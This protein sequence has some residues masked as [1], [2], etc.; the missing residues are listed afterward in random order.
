MNIVENEKNVKKLCSFYVSDFHLVTMLL[1]YVSKK[2]KEDAKIETIL[3]KSI[4]RNM[5]KLI[6]NLNLNQKTKNEISSIGW[7]EKKLVKYN[8]LEKYMKCLLKENG[9]IVLIISGNENYIRGI[10]A[11]L[12]RWIMKNEKLL[13]NQ[14]QYLTII[15]CYEVM[16]FNN[17]MTQ[18]LDQHDKILNTSG[19][20]QIEE[21]FA[22]YERKIIIGQD[23]A[24]A[25]NN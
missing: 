3:D 22:G 11:N 16:Q 25:V 1:P 8:K 23:E 9:N 4:S 10:N 6:A 20:R 24:K 7:N 17:N 5:E 19:E 14:N 15:N 12:D 2:L 21:V 18:I 13:E